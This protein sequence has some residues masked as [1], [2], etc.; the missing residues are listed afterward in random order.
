MRGAS[1]DPS[2]VLAERASAGPRRHHF[3]AALTLVAVVTML[4]VAVVYVGMPGGLA[5]QGS[6]EHSARSNF[7]VVAAHEIPRG[8][9]IFPDM[10]R[11][12]SI[13]G[14]AMPPRTFS[15]PSDVWLSLALVPIH[16][17]EI[18]TND[19]LAIGCSGYCPIPFDYLAVALP[20]DIQG[21]PRS[22]VAGNY[23][24][25]VSTVNT[26]VFSAANPRQV[27]RTVFASVAVIR[28]GPRPAVQG[29]PGSMTVVMSPCDAQY[30]YWL[31]I[32]ASLTYTAGSPNYAAEIASSSGRC[33]LTAG[34]IGP[35]QIDARW[36]F[37]TAGPSHPSQT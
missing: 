37:T 3:G 7:V 24:N 18:I 5:K 31:V 14:T 21:I 29:N 36:G 6:H 34:P 11:T 2:G 16:Q 32:N 28:I 26:D 8:Q 10:V 23:V 20:M 9:R 30:M 35:A 13:S 4:G 1:D 19:L 25:V 27:S 17:N 12:A 33:K 15:K 22:T